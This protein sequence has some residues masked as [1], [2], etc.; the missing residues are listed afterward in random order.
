ME[1]LLSAS[2]LK[3]G[4]TKLSPTLRPLVEAALSG[5]YKPFTGEQVTQLLVGAVRG[6]ECGSR[7]SRGRR[8]QY[9][10][11]E[12]A[13]R[14]WF[15]Y[16]VL[17]NTTVLTHESPE[18]YQLLAFVLVASLA[19]FAG[20]TRMTVTEFSRR[21]KRRNL[22]QIVADQFIGKIG[23]VAAQVYARGFGFD[24]TPDW[25]L[26]RELSRYHT[27]ITHIRR[28][29]ESQ[30][31]NVTLNVSVKS[32]ATLTGI[33]AEAPRQSQV[34][35]FWKVALPED[36][37]FRVL[38]HIS[39]W[40]RFLVFMRQR[41]REEGL[42]EEFIDRL[43]GV[44]GGLQIPCYFEGFFYPSEATLRQKGAKLEFLGEL[45]EAKHMCRTDQLRW[46]T[47]DFEGLL[48]RLYQESI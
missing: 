13:V 40:Q 1:L 20:E 17:P 9:V 29:R 36:F 26:S 22:L 12:D 3:E 28:I 43:T 19:M 4:L 34:A 47:V 38:Q 10:L 27:D 6:G 33:W 18:I 35:L 7:I 48:N 41:V 2:R 45:G 46:S 32:S 11:D 39:S 8:T 24:L 23:E 44:E 42:F 30:R 31:R 37:F 25:E 16:R 15:A 5:D 21:S 14:E